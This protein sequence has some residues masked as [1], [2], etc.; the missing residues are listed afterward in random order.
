MLMAVPSFIRIERG[1]DGGPGPQ[2]KEMTSFC[3]KLANI[4]VSRSAASNHFYCDVNQSNLN[5]CT[6]LKEVQMGTHVLKLL[7]AQKLANINVSRYA[8]PKRA[9]MPASRYNCDVK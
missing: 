4:N 5:V 3:S 7:F 8:I 2:T 6:K 1:S 9:L